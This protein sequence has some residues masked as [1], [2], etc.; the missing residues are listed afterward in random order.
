MAVVASE[1]D[2]LLD[3]SEDGVADLAELV[4]EGVVSD[5][6]VPLGVG[7]GGG[8]TEGVLLGGGVPAVESD[9]VGL[10]AL[11]AVGGDVADGGAA[12]A[13]ATPL[14]CVLAPAVASGAPPP[15]QANAFVSNAYS[16]EGVMQNSV[17]PSGPSAVCVTLGSAEGS[18][19]MYTTASADHVK[20]L[21][22]L[23][24]KRLRPT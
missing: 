19:G 10:G 9:P 5:D 7:E 6:R 22:L 14:N 3:S 13:R 12:G 15:T 24:V 1:A 21:P 23:K 4:A 2:P 11:L 16:A 20:P 17:A 18:P 8:V